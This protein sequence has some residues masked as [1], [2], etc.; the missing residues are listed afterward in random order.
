[1]RAGAATCP[2]QH[3]YSSAGAR[4][5]G[6]SNDAALEDMQAWKKPADAGKWKDA[7]G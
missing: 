3:P 5:T 7:A 1:V 4:V 2:E 6:R